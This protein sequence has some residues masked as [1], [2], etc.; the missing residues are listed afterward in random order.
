MHK[1]TRMKRIEKL[2]N[3]KYRVT[4]DKNDGS[5]KLEKEFDTLLVAIG[6]DPSTN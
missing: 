1:Y 3:D 4:L 2:S 6:R 5:Q